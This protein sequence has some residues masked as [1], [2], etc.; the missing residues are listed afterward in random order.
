MQIKIV[1]V[2]GDK[3]A[4]VLS[5]DILIRETQDALDLMAEIRYMD[6]SKIIIHEN[7]IIPDFFDLKS[8]LAGEILQKFSNYR[9]QL[10]IIGNFSK[11]SAKSFKD[12]IRESNRYRRINFV[13]SFDAAVEKLS[14]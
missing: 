3:I 14:M 11:Y 13:S 7:N 9:M 5:D 6:S 8:K 2:N 12:F 1:T 4:E 10:A